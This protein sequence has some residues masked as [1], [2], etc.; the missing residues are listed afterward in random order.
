MS[1]DLENRFRTVRRQ[2]AGF[3]INTDIKIA[4]IVCDVHLLNR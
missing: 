3:I 2:T 1:P 4:H